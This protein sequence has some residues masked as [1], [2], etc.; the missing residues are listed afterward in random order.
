MKKKNMINNI[1]SRLGIVAGVAAVAG[2]GIALAACGGGAVADSTTQTT[3]ET[4]TEAQVSA[5]LGNEAYKGQTVTG[6]VVSVEGDHITIFTD[7]GES[8]NAGNN[9]EQVNAT[10]EA[11]TDGGDTVMFEVSEDTKYS[12][13]S[14]AGGPGGGSAPQGQPPAKPEGE[15]SNGGSS[16]NG[17]PPAKPEGDASTGSASGNSSASDG[18]S[19]PGGNSG[20]GAV[21]G[22]GDNQPPAKPGGEDSNGGSS[23]NGQPPAKPDGDGSDPGNVPGS[24]ESEDISKDD[25]KADDSV[26]ITI[27]DSGKVTSVVVKSDA[28]GMGMP[29]GAPGGSANIEHTAV[30][31]VTEDTAL[32]GETIESTGDDENALLV[33][34][35]ANVTFTE[36]TLVRS[37][38]TSS[39]GDNASFYGV[40][41]AAL[42]TDGELQVNGTTINTDADGGAGVFAYRDGVA[43]V[44]NATITTKQGASGGIHVAGGGTLYAK[45][46]TVETN[47]R[48]S[49]AIRSDRGGGTMEVDGGTYTSN[50]VGS[51]AIYSTADIMVKNAT[52]TANGSEAICI[53]G[54]NS[55]SLKDCDLTG[56]MSDDEQNDHTWNVIL[57]QSMSGDSEIG[58]STFTMEGGSLTAK[59][60]GMFYSTNTEST[61]V[62]KNVNIT[63][64]DD[65]EYFL[66]VSGNNNK[67]GWGSSGSNGADT[68]FTAI[69]QKMEGKV[70]WDS[71][72]VLDM[73]MTEGSS[74]TGSIEKDDSYAGGGTGGECNIYI[75]EDSTWTVTGDSV[76]TDLYNAGKITDA[77]GKSVTVKDTAGNVLVQGESDYTIT[78]ES[79]TET[80]DLSGAGEL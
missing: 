23:E 51:P 11:V 47:G 38:E 10:T 2:L 39:G 44:E 3:T 28:G 34:E 15:D 69:S 33:K 42:V 71:I 26:S 48:S 31:T 24:G 5:V 59:N 29:G 14:M 67:R 37:S 18:G 30:K 78:V 75:S 52:L 56:N 74:L 62:L 50:G 35:G 60:G 17:Q 66:R 79:Y 8:G 43:Y 6:K 45:D 77:S 7:T 68:S 49:A 80:A 12:K 55:I 73:Y 54:M 61:F 16:E 57:Y 9:S 40:G 27:D 65:S 21:A 63:Y 53:E 1:K 20:S 19:A 25:I 46:L 13:E 4:V 64:A 58:N 70:I 32:T 72:S 41:S 76:V 22:T 36:G